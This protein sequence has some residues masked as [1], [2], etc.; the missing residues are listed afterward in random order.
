MTA[1]LTAKGVPKASLEAVAFKM[2]RAN[3]LLGELRE[4][5]DS[6]L[7]HDEPPVSGAF[8]FDLENGKPARMRPDLEGREVPVEIRGLAG[9]VASLLRIALDHL[10]WQLVLAAGREPKRTTFPNKLNDRADMR[11]VTDAVR[12]ILRR[13][14]LAIDPGLVEVINNLCVIDKHRTLLSGVQKVEGWS[15]TSQ[16]EDDFEGSIRFEVERVIH[17]R[18]TSRAEVVLRSDPGG[19]GG[20]ATYELMVFTSLS[21]PKNPHPLVEVLQNRYETVG[22]LVDALAEAAGIPFG[23]WVDVPRQLRKVDTEAD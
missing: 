2:Q 1:K 6:F 11:G 16:D 21:G 5:V 14:P 10:A 9:E 20:T 3:T 19:F 15:W 13:P 7:G 4:A 18:G 12:D 17:R 22:V 23:S 8:G